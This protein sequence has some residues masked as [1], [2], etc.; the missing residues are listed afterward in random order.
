MITLPI[1]TPSLSNILRDDIALI[2]TLFDPLFPIAQSIE[3][4]IGETFGVGVSV[5]ED[6]I[7]CKLG[8]C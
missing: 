8:N 7:F 4:E 1:I 3:F 6:D 2:M 5:D